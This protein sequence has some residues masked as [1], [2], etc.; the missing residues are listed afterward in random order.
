MIDPS[1]REVCHDTGPF[2][3]RSEPLR[4]LRVAGN[5]L[6]FTIGGR[7]LRALSGR[8]GQPLWSWSTADVRDWFVLGMTRNIPFALWLVSRC[9][10]S[11][12]KP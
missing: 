10:N 8:T 9:L 7:E 3:D 2:L 6:A 1:S 11:R 4:D 12:H 5:V